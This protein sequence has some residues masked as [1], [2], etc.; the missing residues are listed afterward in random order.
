MPHGLPIS[1]SVRIEN[2]IWRWRSEILLALSMETRSRSTG[3][4]IRKRIILGI[5]SFRD[6]PSMSLSPTIYA[7]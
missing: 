3:I 7:K 2:P 6:L 5:I 4:S 1:L